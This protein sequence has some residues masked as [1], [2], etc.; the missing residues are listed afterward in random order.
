M[1]KLRSLRKW[2]LKLPSD[3]IKCIRINTFKKIDDDKCGLEFG[4]AR[5]L[6]CCGENINQYLSSN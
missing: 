5:T 4:A 1:R 2:I 3:T 6:R